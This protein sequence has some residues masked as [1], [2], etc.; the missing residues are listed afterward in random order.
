MLSSIFFGFC[1]FSSWF[2]RAVQSWVWLMAN[3]VSIF[4]GLSENPCLFF[5]PHSISTLGCQVGISVR[6]VA[7]TWPSQR[8]HRTHSWFILILKNTSWDIGFDM[9]RTVWNG[10][11]HYLTLFV[12]IWQQFGMSKLMFYLTLYLTFYLTF[13]FPFLQPFTD[14]WRTVLMMEASGARKPRRSCA[15]SRKNLAC[16]CMVTGPLWKALSQSRR[17][18]WT[19]GN[20]SSLTSSTPGLRPGLRTSVEVLAGM[21]GVEIF[22]SSN[23]KFVTTL[24]STSFTYTDNFLTLTSTFFT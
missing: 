11:R 21:A 22:P 4:K 24:Q 23:F 12:T 6:W 16:H 14:W 7:W 8:S 17:T 10:Y 1:C 2:L 20:W 3:W 5:Q 9:A 15:K 18:C 19:Q 13:Y